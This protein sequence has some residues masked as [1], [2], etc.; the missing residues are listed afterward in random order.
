VPQ[1]PNIAIAPLFMQA[2][3]TFA[4]P[5]NDRSGY[6][7]APMKKDFAFPN[8]LQRAEAS[9]P[10]RKW[11]YILSTVAVTLS[12]LIVFLPNILSS[13]IGRNLLK[14]R[15][16]SKYRGQVWVTDWKT[17]WF[18]PTYVDKFSLTDGQGRQIRFQ[19]LN[20]PIGLWQLLFGKLD[21]KDTTITGLYV[22]YVVDYGDGTNTL[23]RL[24]QGAS[25]PSLVGYPRT[26][27][28]PPVDLPA[29]SGHIKLNDATLVLTRGQIELRD[30]LRTI[31]RSLKLSGISGTLDIASLDRPWECDLTGI[32]GSDDSPGQFRLAGTFALGQNGKLD[33]TRG[34]ANAQLTMLDV[35]NV[36]SFGTSPL[37]WLFFP[38][39]APEDYGVM[40]GPKLREVE[41]TIKLADGKLRLDPLKIEG[42][43]ADGR[44][45]KLT[46]RPVVDLIPTPAVLSLDGEL[47][48]S[49][50]MSR[51]LA[52]R[53][54]F[55][56]PFVHNASGGTGQVDVR[57]ENL[58]MPL[59][60]GNLLRKLSLQGWA[61]MRDV[62]VTSGQS[63]HDYELPR[64][65]TTQWQAI[66]G[67][68][69]PMPKVNAP[70][71]RF[72]VRDG[73]ASCE[74]YRITIDDQAVLLS[75]RA[76]L[77]GPLD[78]QAEMS[79]PAIT[80]QPIKVTVGG[81]VDN[82][83]MQIP[84]DSPLAE[85][86]TRN[87]A[88]L[89]AHRMEH[90]MRMSEAQVREMLEAYDRLS[91]ERNTPPADTPQPNPPQR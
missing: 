68:A 41:T 67:D 84:Q 22:E 77:T 3:A 32:F 61:A 62:T 7:V 60:S 31:Y 23:D 19:Q 25:P 6:I 21:L 71:I 57:L 75:G 90:L 58:S 9:H 2:S 13:K 15:L 4:V 37:G 83:S 33:M 10:R 85:A 53:F 46:A 89:R 59:A 76:R 72:T 66:V 17:R 44:I 91:R 36:P 45:S 52:K 35:P 54:A 74:P 11:K 78:M 86:I 81:T 28:R 5:R 39:F 64:E 12:L 56:N 79:L 43:L 80:A 70:E 1:N 8:P 51:G 26:V 88:S 29:V 47:V 40:F 87:M 73:I 34:M 65:L 14:M 18:G 49:L 69:S 38:D 42:Q 30:Q 55:V 27:A 20:S 50:P 16:E 82:P 63:A 24:P 48:A